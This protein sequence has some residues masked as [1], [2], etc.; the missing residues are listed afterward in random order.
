MIKDEDNT[1]ILLSSLSNEE[2]KTFVLILING[3]QFFSYN[4][5]SASLVN[6]ELRRKDKEFS[7]STSSMTLAARRIGSNH[8]KVKRGIGNSK[9]GNRKLEKNQ[10]A[11]CKEEGH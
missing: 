3:E 4:E 6:H 7:N 2:Y 1:L 5:V 9:I 8:G 10:C 11:L